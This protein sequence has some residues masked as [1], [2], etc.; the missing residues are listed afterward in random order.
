MAVTRG[1]M[2]NQ[3]IMSIMLTQSYLLQRDVVLST[4]GML[5]GIKENFYSPTAARPFEI[6]AEILSLSM[7]GRIVFLVR[8]I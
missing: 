5:V 4:T 6:E 8:N 2:P 1:V 7:N 3:S